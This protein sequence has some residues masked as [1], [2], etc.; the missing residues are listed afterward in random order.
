MLTMPPHREQ[1]KVR[2][3]KYSV[4]QTPCDRGR[5]RETTY[6]MKSGQSAPQAKLRDRKEWTFLMWETRAHWLNQMTEIWVAKVWYWVFCHL[7]VSFYDLTVY[8]SVGITLLFVR[9]TPAYLGGHWEIRYGS[10]TLYP[11][12]YG[13]GKPVL[14]RAPHRSYSR[15]VTIH[16]YLFANG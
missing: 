3:S 10:P 4:N 14:F 11:R 8:T 5:L 13:W 6:W 15:I 9:G 16:F 2:S 12:W 1:Q 7:V